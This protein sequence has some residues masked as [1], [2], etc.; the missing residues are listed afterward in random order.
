[1]KKLRHSQMRNSQSPVD[2][3]AG[4]NFRRPMGWLSRSLLILLIVLL[5][6]A[7]A[8][9]AYAALRPLV[10]SWKTRVYGY[11]RSSDVSYQ[12]EVKP[13]PIFSD[14][15]LGM[16]LVYTDKYTQAI[17]PVFK[18]HWQADRETPLTWQSEIVVTLRVKDQQDPA[19]ILFEKSRVSGPLLNGSVT[20]DSFDI[21]RSVRVN[22]DDYR[23][24][25]ETFRTQSDLAASF[26]LIIGLHTSVQ[27]DLT[28]GP[29][30]IEDTPA[31]VLP[32]DVETFQITR[33]PVTEPLVELE[34]PIRYQLVVAPIPFFVYPL[35]GGILF[36]L[37]ILTLIFTKTRRKSP[38][39][40]ELGKMLRRARARLMLIGDKAWEPEW[41]VRTT[42][43]PTMV[44][45][46]IKLKHP[47]FC[48]IDRQAA[49]PAAYFYVYY[50]ENNY[51]Y[52]FSAGQPGQSARPGQSGAGAA[53]GDDG[54]PDDG[55]RFH[56][57]LTAGSPDS[58]GLDNNRD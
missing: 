42:D 51:C 14:S 13:N 27:A 44:R 57:P 7:T 16:N 52:T 8:A 45:T 54:L 35:V 6:A 48:Y 49:V 5:L 11:E 3:S 31:L 24:L 2:P 32:L 39:E 55:L 12:V 50:G 47:I 17:N 46:A 4:K 34:R 29:L 38:F 23:A 58:E 41:C 9:A 1:M 56:S 33:S 21:E 10:L 37:L 18:Y 22:L 26:D 40:R 30:T 15:M 19:R 28:G 53:R 20:G 25:I 36:I 43:F